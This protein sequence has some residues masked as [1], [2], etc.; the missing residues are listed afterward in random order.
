[1][2]EAAIEPGSRLA[3]ILGVEKLMVNSGH[4]QAAGR[5][6]SGLRV[7]ARSPDGVV[8]A[9]ESKGGRFILGVQWHPEHLAA[10][11]PEHLALFR[12]LV[13]AAAAEADAA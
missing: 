1:M 3:A 12:A 9:I 10:T 8:E 2:H 13:D 5:I 4:H 11:Q 6:G 7:C